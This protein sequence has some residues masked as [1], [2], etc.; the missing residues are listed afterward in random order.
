MS[1]LEHS[2]ELQ[3][4]FELYLLALI[5]TVLGLA[6]Q[7]AKFGTYRVADV[8]EIV[9]WIALVA[10]GVSGLWRMEWVPVALKTSAQLQG[11]RKERRELVE[12]ANRGVQRVQIEDEPEPADVHELIAARDGIIQRGQSRLDEIERAIHMKY[13]IHKWTFVLGLA[14]L[15][16]A[17]SYA[18]VVGLFGHATPQASCEQVGQGNTKGI[19]SKKHGGSS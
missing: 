11:V 18:P 7:T 17:R 15:I 2:R 8:S 4:K 5:F 6:I 19:Q 13:A 9:G 10:S 1:E 3:E 12:H 14:L 16:V